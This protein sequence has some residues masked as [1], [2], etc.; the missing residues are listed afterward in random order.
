MF[1]SAKCSRLYDHPQFENHYSIEP[2]C[3]F[4]SYLEIKNCQGRLS[5]DYPEPSNN[6]Q[7]DF[8]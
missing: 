4:I 8:L 5:C 1:I 6:W 3:V 2:D 7:A